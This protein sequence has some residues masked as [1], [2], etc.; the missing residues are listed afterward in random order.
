MEE[1]ILNESID[2]KRNTKKIVV[3]TKQQKFDA[4]VLATVFKLAKKNSDPNFIQYS[5]HLSL[6]N[7]FR[8]KLKDKYTGKAKLIARKLINSAKK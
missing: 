8:N 3:K 2:Y 7:A 4:L 5:K 6:A 1:E